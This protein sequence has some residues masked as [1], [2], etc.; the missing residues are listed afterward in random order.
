MIFQ[1]LFFFITPKKSLSLILLLNTMVFANNF[2]ITHTEGDKKICSEVRQKLNKMVVYKKSG[3]KY[4]HLDIDTF[5]PE[6]KDFYKEQDGS[7]Y[8]KKCPN[9][10]KDDRFM[11]DQYAQIR[12]SEIEVNGTKKTIMWTD[13]P[14]DM[15]QGTMAIVDTD[16]CAY[17]IVAQRYN[18]RRSEGNP[19]WD[20]YD[21]VRLGKTYYLKREY[22]FSDEKFFYLYPLDL[23]TRISD[24]DASEQRCVVTIKKLKE[25]K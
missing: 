24:S 12:F 6:D 9:W 8:L 7:M 17:K 2:T 13:P 23:N 14:G 11:E 19:P 4:I 1:P 5:S 15:V 16:T 21:L 3:E 22:D 20:Q 10:F 18:Y 25:E